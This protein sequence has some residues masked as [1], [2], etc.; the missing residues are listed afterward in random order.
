MIGIFEMGNDILHMQ[1]HERT[2]LTEHPFAILAAMVARGRGDARDAE[3]VRVHLVGHVALFRA[4]TGDFAGARATLARISDL[5]DLPSTEPRW[6]RPGAPTIAGVITALERDR[7]FHT[8]GVIYGALDAAI[9]RASRW[10]GGPP[11]GVG[12]RRA[13]ARGPPGARDR[14]AVADDGNVRGPE[15]SLT[16]GRMRRSG[17]RTQWILGASPALT[18][19]SRPPYDRAPPDRPPDPRR[20]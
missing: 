10:R 5:L 13:A 15:V 4:A 3:E 19:P 14:R 16:G 9:E 7:A 8:R 11:G 6:T 1:R 20:K 12:C 17:Q 2:H 18:E